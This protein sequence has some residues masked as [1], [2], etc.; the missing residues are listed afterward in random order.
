MGNSY[1][2]CTGGE[3]YLSMTPLAIACCLQKLFSSLKAKTF[4]VI[5]YDFSCS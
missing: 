4:I 2:V 5:I 3:F 1:Q